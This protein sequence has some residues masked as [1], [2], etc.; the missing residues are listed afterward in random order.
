MYVVNECDECGGSGEICEYCGL[1]DRYA[2]DPNWLSCRCSH[3]LYDGCEKCEGTGLHRV[4]ITALN[5]IPR[6]S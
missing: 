3:A 2:V 5:A 1:P 4:L 6:E